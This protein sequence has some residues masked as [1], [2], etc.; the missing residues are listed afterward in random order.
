[1]MSEKWAN[2]VVRELNLEGNKVEPKR[3][4]DIDITSSFAHLNPNLRID[5]VFG[6]R[7]ASVLESLCNGR[8]NIL[9][10]DYDGI[11]PSC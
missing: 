4:V 3:Y 11:V 7:R 1:M 2:Q 5:E 9:L 8:V 6:Y 10:M